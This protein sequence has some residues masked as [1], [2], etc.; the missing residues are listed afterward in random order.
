MVRASPE[1]MAAL[2]KMG[3]DE[4]R[5]V[6]EFLGF[7]HSQVH[8]DNRPPPESEISFSDEALRN[9]IVRLLSS[10]EQNQ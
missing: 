9:V 4:Y 7:G 2:A 8:P 3:F 5:T 6:V 10:S 1:M